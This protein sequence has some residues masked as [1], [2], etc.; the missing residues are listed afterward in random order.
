MNHP[1][2]KFGWNESGEEGHQLRAS[3]IRWTLTLCGCL[4]S[5]LECHNKV[6]WVV[7]IIGVVGCGGY[8]ASILVMS[9][10]VSL[11]GNHECACILLRVLRFFWRDMCMMM[12]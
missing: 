3:P 10:V 9:L 1:K 12:V 6:V 7:C 8:L 4:V 2:V 5:S 11:L